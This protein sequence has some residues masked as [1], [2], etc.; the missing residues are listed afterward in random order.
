MMIGK[1]PHRPGGL[2]SAMARDDM[3]VG[4]SKDWI[5][6]AKRFDGCS[7]LID[8]ALR[9][10]A[11]V[12]RIGNEIADRAVGDGQPRREQGRSRLIHE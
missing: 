11:G 1:K 10:G 7:D 12:A 9:M 3:A 2:N 4:I 5:G 6:E 8:L